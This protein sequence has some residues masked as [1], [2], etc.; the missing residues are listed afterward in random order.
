[1][2]NKLAK[3]ALRVVNVNVPVKTHKIIRNRLYTTKTHIH[4]HSNTHT[5]RQKNPHT[6]FKYIASKIL[7]VR[8][9]RLLFP[10]PVPV[11]IVHVCAM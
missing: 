3:M 7:C 10:F 9:A 5:H 6:D 2:I 1:M 8:I 4:S 11:P